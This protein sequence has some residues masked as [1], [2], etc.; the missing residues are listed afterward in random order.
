[1]KE[2]E[3]I[4]EFINKHH[5]E[6]SRQF[7]VKKIGLFGSAAKNNAASGSD[8]DFYVSFSK[9]NFRNLTGLYSYLEKNL[10]ERIGIVTDHPNIRKS[11]K[12]EIEESVLYG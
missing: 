6:I 5:D 10:G 7:G 3:E 2:A 1:M 12:K 9:K 4:L 11:L 8:L